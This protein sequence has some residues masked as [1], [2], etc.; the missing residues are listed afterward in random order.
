[1]TRQPNSPQS[2][3]L[4]V[5]GLVYFEV[6]LPD[7]ITEITPGRETFVDHIDIRAGGAL[8]CA[9]VAASLGVDTTVAYPCGDGLTDAAITTEVQRLFIRS[10]AWQTGDDPAI[11]LVRSDTGDRGFLSRADYDALDDCPELTG[12]DWIHVPGLEEAH[13]LEHRLDEARRGGTP[14]SV[15][16]SWNPRRLDALATFRHPRWDLLFLNRDEARRAAGD[17]APPRELLAQLTTAAHNIVIT[18]G[19]RRVHA[20]VDD[21]R[22]QRDVPPAPE[23][24]DTTGAGDAFAAGYVAARLDGAAP[25]TALERAGKAAATVVG[26][27]GGVVQDPTLLG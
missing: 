21:A 18:D 2:S 22:L 16:A 24:V 14:I 19:P 13:R 1:M 20:L 26:L 10:R 6:F 27:A 9:S 25:D 11:S 8:N 5:A 23:V 3:R 12:Y 4:C 15:S 17:D 7:E